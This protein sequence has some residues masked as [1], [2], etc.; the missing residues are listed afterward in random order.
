MEM[1]NADG[2][3]AL[4]VLLHPHPDFGGNRY[5]PFIDC[6]FRRL[7]EIDIGTVRFDVSSADPSAAHEEVVAAIVV[8]EHDQFSPPAAIAHTVAGWEST[9]TSTVPGAD[10]FVRNVQ[11]IID[12]AKDWI[13]RVTEQ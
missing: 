4:G 11:P 6:L 13:G 3:R 12:G 5:H 8:P 2:G 1:N 7:P 9:E 10:H